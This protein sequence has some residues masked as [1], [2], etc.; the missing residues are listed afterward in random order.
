[1]D[2]SIIKIE[3]VEEDEKCFAR[4]YIDTEGKI[5]E[6]NACSET[7]EE[8]IMKHSEKTLKFNIEKPEE[9]FKVEDSERFIDG[10][11]DSIKIE[12]NKNVEKEMIP[13]RQTCLE[14]QIVNLKHSIK[15][16]IVEDSIKEEEVDGEIS[17][18]EDIELKSMN[19]V[20]VIIQNLE[21]ILLRII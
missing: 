19:I 4:Q 7:Y 10:K 8:K 13:C 20:F 5:W 17:T 3:P 14:N 9:C 18:T 16:E 2:F 1:M 12:E 11:G 21:S 15:E 6:L